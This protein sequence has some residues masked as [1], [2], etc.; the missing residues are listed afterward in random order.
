[1]KRPILVRPD[2]MRPAIT[3]LFLFAAWL[4]LLPLSCG[5]RA[6]VHW[7][8]GNFKVYATDEDLKATRLG[9]DHHPGILTLVEGEV[10]AA[11]STAQLVFVQRIDRASH[12]TE[13]YIIP[14]EQSEESHSGKVEGPL[15]ETQFR[16]IRISRQ[17]PEFTWKKK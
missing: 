10:V 4:A 15:S 6:D 11:G 8:D 7:A 1:M 13:F 9:Y 16:E 3:S 5:R 14:K 2:P 17:L 12:R